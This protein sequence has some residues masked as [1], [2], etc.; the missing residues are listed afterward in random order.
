VDHNETGI[1]GQVDPRANQKARTKTAIVD[2]ACQLVREGMIPTVATAAERARVSR[3]TAYRYFP[4]QEDLGEA[5]SRLHPAIAA[6]DEVVDSFDTDDVEARVLQ[7]VDTYNPLVISDQVAMR[8]TLAS[9]QREWLRAHGQ[10]TTPYVRSQTCTRWLDEALRPLEGLPAKQ[11]KRLRAALALSLGIESIVV[12][13]DA[14]QLDDREALAV[15][16]WVAAALL[17]A[18]INETI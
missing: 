12:M 13:Q 9:F 16:H 1:S 17:Q 15:L 14:C 10:G 7:V 18:T 2:A 6:V 5:L 3:A 8:T 4:T 11:R